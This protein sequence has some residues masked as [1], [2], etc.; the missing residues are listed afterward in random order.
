MRTKHPP[1]ETLAISLQNEE[2]LEEG[3]GRLYFSDMTHHDEG[4]DDPNTIQSQLARD[5]LVCLKYF[6]EKGMK[7]KSKSNL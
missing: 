6:Y 4:A 7:W 2:G 5:Y 3:E 1:P